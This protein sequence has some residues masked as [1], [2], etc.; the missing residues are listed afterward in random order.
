M[1]YNLFPELHM[2]VLRADPDISTGP[3]I[4]ILLPDPNRG[5]NF[6]FSQI[7]LKLKKNYQNKQDETCW[8]KQYG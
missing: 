6:T 8:E 7:Q 3:V 4:F 1:R 2:L 5:S